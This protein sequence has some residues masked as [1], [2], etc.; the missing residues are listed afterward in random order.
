[1]AAVLVPVAPADDPMAPQADSASPMAS[2]SA[3]R[4][5]ILALR[6]QF[7]EFMVASLAPQMDQA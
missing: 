1:V 2:P 3:E 6:V 7:S 4:P 5:A